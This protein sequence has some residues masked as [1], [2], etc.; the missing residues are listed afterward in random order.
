MPFPLQSGPILMPSLEQPPNS[1]NEPLIIL[2][3]LLPLTNQAALGAARQ[4]MVM[5]VAACHAEILRKIVCF[6][7][8]VCR[9]F[10]EESFCRLEGDLVDGDF[11]MVF[12]LDVPLGHE[13]AA[14]QA[15]EPRTFARRA[16]SFS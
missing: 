3:T 9:F 16:F 13:G 15:V 14:L 4:V 7:V 10:V 12:L 6:L 5:Y 2:M 8:F 11:L 1:I